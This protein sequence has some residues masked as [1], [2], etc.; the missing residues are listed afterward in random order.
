MAGV[1]VGLSI[2]SIVMHTRFSQPKDRAAIIASV[3]V[4]VS[5]TF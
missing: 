2:G 4:Y 5:P 1:G 3:G